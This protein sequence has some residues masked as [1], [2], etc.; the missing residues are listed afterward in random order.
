MNQQRQYQISKDLQEIMQRPYV[1]PITQV[2]MKDTIEIAI[3]LYNMQGLVDIDSIEWLDC[4]LTVPP[5][6][7]V[8]TYDKDKGA[9]SS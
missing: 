5:K 7:N 6:Y 4:S 1:Q 9:R 8:I 3:N 2:C